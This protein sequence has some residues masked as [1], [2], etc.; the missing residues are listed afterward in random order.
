MNRTV[1][2][3]SNEISKLWEEAVAAVTKEAI[4]PHLI[5]FKTKMEKATDNI[6]EY[7]GEIDEVK[8]E[9]KESKKT[10]SKLLNKESKREKQFLSK[11][12]EFDAL[13]K[14]TEEYVQTFKDEVTKHQ[15]VVDTSKT[16]L[17]KN[18][19]RLENLF[20]L[21]GK[22]ND[23]VVTKIEGFLKSQGELQD[24]IKN[25]FNK[26]IERVE[27]IRSSQK[28]LTT[29]FQKYVEEDSKR[30]ENLTLE[31]QQLKGNHEE[32]VGSLSEQKNDLDSLRSEQQNT[33]D[34]VQKNQ[35]ILKDTLK[36]IETFKLESSQKVVENLNGLEVLK[37]KQD[38]FVETFQK[39]KEEETNK[40]ELFAQNLSNLQREQTEIINTSN[41]RFEESKI[42]FENVK[43]NQKELKSS[44]LHMQ[45]LL[46]ET[47][48][49]LGTFQQNV[50][51]D[52]TK[53]QEELATQISTMKKEVEQSNSTIQ[54]QGLSKVRDF[55]QKTE[56][57]IQ[58]IGAEIGLVKD[59]LATVV[60]Q[61][62][63]LKSQQIIIFI[64]G[65]LVLF[66]LAVGGW[67]I[68]QGYIVL[69][70]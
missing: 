35:R 18:T 29:K 16:V 3:N 24:D 37:N 57:D 30:S 27:G 62:Q 5:P 14:R 49:L 63:K 51:Q 12:E 45:S 47:F 4:E 46:N 39:E 56:E 67:F 48:E 61:T 7:L 13:S 1:K 59:Q 6:E 70:E 19:E 2:K 9:M 42:E 55:S 65:M 28:D 17:L 50:N 58:V 53:I 41:S 10:L 33:N 15:E 64:L 54:E 8:E 44:F 11:V 22:S 20:D 38:L 40:R 69:Q 31:I 36:T 32:L 21:I 60:E 23:E 68:S 34:E 66:G 43:S 25:H 26:D 52:I